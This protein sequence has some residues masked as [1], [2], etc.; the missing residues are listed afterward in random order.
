[1]TRSLRLTVC[2]LHDDRAAFER[3][4]K[5]LAAH[6]RDCRSELVLL[7]EMPF[8]ELSG[9]SRHHMARVAGIRR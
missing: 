1:M 6:V 5:R 3:D 2:E 8:A 4:W 7:P 9:V